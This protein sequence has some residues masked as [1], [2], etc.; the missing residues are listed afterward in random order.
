MPRYDVNQHMSSSRLQHLGTSKEPAIV[1]FHLP[2]ISTLKKLP[3]KKNW[4][5]KHS[6]F[7]LEEVNISGLIYYFKTYINTCV[8]IK[9]INRISTPL[10][11]ATT[12]CK[13]TLAYNTAQAMQTHRLLHTRNKLQMLV[14]FHKQLCPA[15]QTRTDRSECWVHSS[16]PNTLR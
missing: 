3:R 4:H 5:E 12:T 10:L 15:E 14:H 16:V 11:R 9:R 8:N 13:N 1:I 6:S 7:A 2:F